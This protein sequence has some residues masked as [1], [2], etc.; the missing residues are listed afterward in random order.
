MMAVAMIV[1][2]LYG[3]KSDHS[4]FVQFSQALEGHAVSAILRNV[5]PNSPSDTLFVSP[6]AFRLGV[7]LP[8]GLRLLK[9][10]W[11]PL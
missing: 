6:I 1:T 4:P 2:S 11:N 5:T 9:H 10:F 7:L 3:K 8:Q